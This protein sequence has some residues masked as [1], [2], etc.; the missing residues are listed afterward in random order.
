[1]MF[2]S[3][4]LTVGGD[5]RLAAVNGEKSF[6]KLSARVREERERV[7]YLEAEYSYIP[8]YRIR[9][10]WDPD[11]D[12]GNGAYRPCDYGKQAI[13]LELGSDR[14]LPVDLVAGW[15]YEAYRYDAD[16]VEYDAGASTTSARAI[17]RPARGLRI[18]LGYA[19]RRS[20]ARGYDEDGET[21]STS[22]ES[23]TTYDEDEY[24]LR[25]R[26]EAGRLWGLSAAL[27]ARASLARRFYLTEKGAETDPYHAGRDD[28]YVTLGAG[29]EARL[30]EAATAELFVE[31]RSREAHSDVVPDIG[32]TKDYGAGRIGLKLTVE[33]VH[34]LD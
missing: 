6:G 28:T 22:D 9:D 18:D 8:S 20:S 26:W 29:V 23:D 14:S 1:M 33:G 31:W 12:G 15:T 30:S 27:R 17:V 4:V 11:A 24:E 5:L 32:E 3:T 25:A 13:H 2:R 16:F 21:R 34:F 19:L 7:A 10:L